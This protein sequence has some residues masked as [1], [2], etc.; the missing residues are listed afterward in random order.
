M[1][2]NSMKAS[3][4][5]L[6]IKTKNKKNNKVDAEIFFETFIYLKINAF[7]SFYILW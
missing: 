2:K 6:L 3:F 1:F 7:Y 4:S 5:G